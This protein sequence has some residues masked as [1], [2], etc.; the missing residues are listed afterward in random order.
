MKKID[1]DTART[2]RGLSGG[3]FV[4]VIAVF[5]LL[6]MCAEMFPNQNPTCHARGCYSEN[7]K[8]YVMYQFGKPHYFDWCEEHGDPEFFLPH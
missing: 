4:G 1:A 8:T 3:I 6:S 5:G 7:T 2:A